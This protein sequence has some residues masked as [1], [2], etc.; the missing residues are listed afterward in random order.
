MRRIDLAAVTLESW[1]RLDDRQRQRFAEMFLR[2]ALRLGGTELRR[3]LRR[4]VRT[5]PLAPP[6]D[7]SRFA[8]SDD[9]AAL[10]KA[11][12]FRAGDADRGTGP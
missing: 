12:P 10:L 3:W 6:V 8:I 2:A 9:M 4:R 11:M 7:L 1:G 5:A